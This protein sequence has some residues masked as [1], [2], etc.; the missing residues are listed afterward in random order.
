MYKKI[1]ATYNLKRREYLATK[2]ENPRHTTHQPSSA[3]LVGGIP[4]P[5]LMPRRPLATTIVKQASHRRSCQPSVYPH[6]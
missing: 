2:S 6:S 5:C 1:K 3:T 4:T